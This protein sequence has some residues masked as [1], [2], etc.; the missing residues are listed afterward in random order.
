MEA[1]DCFS[2]KQSLSILGSRLLIFKC[3]L[4][5]TS[6]PKIFHLQSSSAFQDTELSHLKDTEGSLH[7]RNGRVFKVMLLLFTVAKPGMTFVSPES[8]KINLEM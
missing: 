1:I 2:I 3:H 8:N 5:K 7:S 6:F 4:C